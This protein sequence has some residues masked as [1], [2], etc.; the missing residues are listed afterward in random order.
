MYWYKDW[1]AWQTYI[2]IYRFDIKYN[3]KKYI[4]TIR[5]NKGKERTRKANEIKKFYI[6][7]YFLY[8]IF[9]HFSRT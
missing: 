1:M 3:K 4:D 9:I 7:F 6:P 8:I 2:F 5:S